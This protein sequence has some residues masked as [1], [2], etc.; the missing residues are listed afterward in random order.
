MVLN[1]YTSIQL[2][3]LLVHVPDLI[4][5]TY[6]QQQHQHHHPMII[7]LVVQLEQVLDQKVQRCASMVCNVCVQIVCFLIHECHFLY[8]EITNGSIINGKIVF[9]K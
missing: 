4:V 3:V 5:H 2:V 6:I 9:M 7:W 1:V 8:H